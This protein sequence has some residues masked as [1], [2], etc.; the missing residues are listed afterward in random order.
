MISYAGFITASGT[1]P[2]GSVGTGNNGQ[3]YYSSTTVD[4]GTAIPTVTPDDTG[5]LYATTKKSWR[6]SWRTD[7]V[8]VIQ[9]SIP[10]PAIRPL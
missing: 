7:T 4:Y 8:D 6:G 10:T 3:V 5:L 2:A 9:G 1:I